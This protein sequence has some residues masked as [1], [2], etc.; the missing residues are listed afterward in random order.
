[1][2]S[3]NDIINMP[4]H[5]SGKHRPMSGRAAQFAPFAAL[6][7]YD[8]CI[9]ETSRLTDEKKE[10]TPDIAAELE[11]KTAFLVETEQDSPFVTIEYFVPDEKKSGGRYITVSGNFKRIDEYNNN[12]ILTNGNKIPLDDIFRL[13]VS[14]FEKSD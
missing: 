5:I 3:Y 11:K 2:N 13:E 9:E 7:G 10:L 12:M 1:M 6:T 14:Y 8:D 4:H